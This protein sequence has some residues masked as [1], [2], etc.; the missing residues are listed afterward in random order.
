MPINSNKTNVMTN[1]AWGS[2]I[3]NRNFLSSTGFKF[4]LAEEPKVDFF[5]NFANI[6]AITLGS[7]IITRYGKNIDIPGD[8]MNFDD[9]SLRFIVDEYLEN[10]NTIQN[11]MRG[12][13]FPESL[14]Q[15]KDFKESKV[16]D[17]YQSQKSNFFETSDGTLQILGSNFTSIGKVV[18]TGL[19][20]VYL[21]S[22]EFDAT[23]QDI[24]YFTAQVTFKYTYYEI[25]STIDKPI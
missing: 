4:N 14:E 11:W 8:K 12:L 5:S 10:Y 17:N 6:P 21:S 22:L 16:K 3:T 23:P 24:N 2:Q 19:F 18:Y 7:S 25:I 13:G 20:P 9:F 1:S 15:Y